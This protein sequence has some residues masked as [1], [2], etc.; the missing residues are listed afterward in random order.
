MMFHECMSYAVAGSKWIAVSVVPMMM[1]ASL[2]PPPPPLPPLDEP[3]ELPQP[4]ASGTTAAA[5]TNRRRPREVRVRTIC[6]PLG[7]A[8]AGRRPQVSGRDAGPSRRF[9]ASTPSDVGGKVNRGWAEVPVSSPAVALD[10]L[11][12]PALIC[13]PGAALV[14]A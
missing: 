13:L 8:S 3:L 10:L 9:D 2:F 4:A 5:N 7:P 12:L 6:P 14:R 1:V 11:W